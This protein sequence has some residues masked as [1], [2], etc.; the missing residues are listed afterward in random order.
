MTC[1]FFSVRF[2]ASQSVENVCTLVR[3][4]VGYKVGP[5]LEEGVHK[6]SQGLQVDAV[7]LRLLES[8]LLERQESVDELDEGF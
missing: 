3:M 7:S 8:Q 2:Y 4:V 5:F 1:V 6:R